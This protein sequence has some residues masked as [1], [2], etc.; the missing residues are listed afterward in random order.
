MS[1]ASPFP[2]SPVPPSVPA[3]TP[4]Q[5]CFAAVAAQLKGKP[6]SLVVPLLCAIGQAERHAKAVPHA[7][8]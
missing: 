4:Y 5:A 1:Q 8:P 2:R 7:A 3:P 6:A